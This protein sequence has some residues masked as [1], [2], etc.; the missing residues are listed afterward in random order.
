MGA[1]LCKELITNFRIPGVLSTRF[2]VRAFDAYLKHYATNLYEADLADPSAV[3]YPATEN[4]WNSATV[5]PLRYK[6][7]YASLKSF[8]Q[9]RGIHF[10]P[11]GDHSHGY[12]VSPDRAEVIFQSWS[13]TLGP[14]A[15]S[16]VPGDFSISL[17]FGNAHGKLFFDAYSADTGKK[18]VTIVMKF[19]SIFPE[20]VF[21]RT[22]WVTER[23]FFVPLDQRRDKCLICDFGRK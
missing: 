12:N 15:G 2:L 8:V 18:L 22:G 5:V 14:G 23:Y 3:P 7:P 21:D 20:E 17:K 1:S 9:S 10:V 11:G 19:V 13:G 6:G 16:D 4:A